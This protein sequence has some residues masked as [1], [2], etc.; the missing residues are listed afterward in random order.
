MYRKHHKWTSSPSSAVTFKPLSYNISTHLTIQ[1]S[2][3]KATF[4]ISS[5]LEI[6]I[7]PSSNL[8]LEVVRRPKVY[9]WL[10]SF[11]NTSKCQSILYTLPAKVCILS[12]H[13]FFTNSKLTG[14]PS[15][16]TEST[17]IHHLRNVLDFWYGARHWTPQDLSKP[18][19]CAHHCP[20]HNCWCSQHT[21]WTPLH[22]QI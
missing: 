1:E 13:S 3:I 17:Q 11:F 22:S 20:S 15:I 21:F 8:F 4:H 12:R 10:I 14:L 16:I 6:L 7:C 9:D 2:V 19:E 5:F 18:D